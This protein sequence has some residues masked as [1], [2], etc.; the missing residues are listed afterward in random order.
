MSVRAKEKG[1]SVYFVGLLRIHSSY[2]FFYFSFF[3]EGDLNV[4]GGRGGVCNF[5]VI[6]KTVISQA[7]T[8]GEI[9]ESHMLLYRYNIKCC[10]SFENQRSPM[11]QCTI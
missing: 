6:S 11:V 2:L 9:T 5:R 4:P 10:D 8:A 1:G 7:L 3:W